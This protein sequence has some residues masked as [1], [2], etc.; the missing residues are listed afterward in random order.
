MGIIRA[1]EVKLTNGRSAFINPKYIASVHPRTENTTTVIMS[2]GS[3]YV[4]DENYKLLM[5]N[6]SNF[7]PK[8]RK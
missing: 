7:K 1:V 2:N 5:C 8:Y 3:V 6:L 4:V